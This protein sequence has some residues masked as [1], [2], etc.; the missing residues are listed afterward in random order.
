[1]I[2]AL[3]AVGLAADPARVQSA[4]ALLALD[5][6]FAAETMDMIDAVY[7]RRYGEAEAR[8]A[9]A[10]VEWPLSGV[11]PFGIAIL[12]QARMYENEDECCLP[13]Y[14]R[15]RDAARAQLEAGQ[16]TPGNEAF[17]MLIAGGVDGLDAVHLM[18]RKQYLG[19]LAPAY[20][21]LRALNRARE[22][23]PAL[24]DPVLGHGMFLYWRT[25][26]SRRSA[27]LPDFAD[28]RP[29]GV[30]LLRRAEREALFLGPCA[31]LALVYAHVEA[32]DWPAA[33]AQAEKIAIQY[34]DNALN[35]MILAYALRRSG[36]LGA[37]VAEY[38]KVSPE[39]YR[40][41]FH[42]GQALV[43]MGRHAEGAAA[44][45]HYLADVRVP[46][47]LRPTALYWLGDAWRGAGDAVRAR[48]AWTSAADLGHDGAAASLR[49]L[50]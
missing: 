11:G 37:A 4:V 44:I 32:Q 20:A 10:T 40:A 24:A 46:S 31:G 43:V 34:P 19:A 27:L 16:D 25:V 35:R 41:E 28:R 33:I 22:V 9:R 18:R 42:R 14:E 45:E 7:A 13:D 5:P 15:G 50:P 49:T 29:E 2:L 38:E 3:F 39:V 26:I 47:G 8:F 1:M 48:A 21:G 30:E 23:V 17:E 6:R 36:R 12:A